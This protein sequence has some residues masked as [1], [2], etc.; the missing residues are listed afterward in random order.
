LEELLKTILPWLEAA[1]PTATSPETTGSF[2]V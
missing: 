1:V 2:N